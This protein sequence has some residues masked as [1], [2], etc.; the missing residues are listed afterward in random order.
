MTK[1]TIAPESGKEP[2]NI[3]RK[4]LLVRLYRKAIEEMIASV[5][6]RVAA[7]AKVERS[8]APQV[9]RRENGMTSISDPPLFGGNGPTEHTKLFEPP[10]NDDAARQR[11][12]YP[13]DEFPA[14]QGLIDFIRNNGGLTRAYPEGE[15]EVVLEIQVRLQVEG[16]VNLHLIKEGTSAWSG[17]SDRAILSPLLHGLFDERLELAIVVPIALTRFAFDRF[18]IAPD[19]LIVRIGEGFHRAR[20][21]AKAYGGS[22][23]DAVLAAATHALIITGWGVENGRHWD[24]SQRL[25]GFGDEAREVVETVFATVRMVTGIDTGYAQML[26]LARHWRMRHHLGDPE[27]FAAGARRY[28]DAFDDF[29]WLQDDIPTISRAEAAD[30]A[31]SLT[32]IRRS[33]D[34]RLSLALRRLNGAMTRDE[35]ADA[36]LDATIGLELLLGDKDNQAISWKLRMR[37]AALAGLRGGRADMERMSKAVADVYALR[38]SIVHGAGRRSSKASAT[39]PTVGKRLAI[40][41]LRTVLRAI[42]AMPRY[43]DPLVVDRELMMVPAAERARSDRDEDEHA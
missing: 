23:H 21:T 37:A 31:S 41:T 16:A 42:V 35:P 38:S 33:G 15:H 5:H 1:D 17:R 43:L 27:V 20:W 7:G 24:L 19:A 11:G 13:P 12:P 25:R 28:P 3:D 6:A 9:S 30:V 32:S 40:D 39:G 14:L 29:G 4:L 22:G 18:R 10:Y 8:R 26:W 36:I 2:D 34:P